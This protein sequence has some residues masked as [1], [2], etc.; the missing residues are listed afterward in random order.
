V[1]RLLLGAP[2]GTV[3]LGFESGEVIPAEVIA[4]FPDGRKKLYQLTQWL[5]VLEELGERHRVLLVTRRKSAFDELAER[6]TLQAAHAPLLRHL[7][8]LYA[9]ND[10]KVALYVNNG[11]R[12][13]QSLADQSML[14]VHV[15]HGESD[16]LCMVSNQVKA[17]DRVLVAGEA[18]LRRHRAALLAFDEEKL[19]TVGRPQLDFIPEP[20]IP[21]SERR[22]VLYAPTWEGEDE[23]N[24]YT[25]VD[26]YGPRIVQTVLTQPNVRV[27][28]KPHP[29]VAGSADEGVSAGHAR[30]VALIEA[31]SEADPTAGH[32]VQLDGDILALLPACD[33]MV[34]DVS[35]VALDFL[36]LNT[37][38]PL[39]LTDRRDDPERLAREAPVSRAS[40]VIDSSSLDGLAR[41]LSETS[42]DETL[43]AERRELRRF[44]FGDL[45][46][47]QSTE[48]FVACVEELIR[49]R[50]KLMAEQA[51][52]GLLRGLSGAE[53]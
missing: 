34:A 22:T 33:V 6:T 11:V 25:S 8:E 23:E 53:D 10:F 5:P 18:A 7:S 51:E 38:R 43:R 21:P 31:A 4:Y 27:V 42:L 44:Y 24:N 49:E 47:G 9:S 19:A 39:L 16:K 2:A 12:N 50:D 37:D 14:H 17:Y 48:R 40:H 45:G 32:T 26:V 29:R 3:P 28:Y 30:I 36:Y 15:N 52:S 1:H 20:S 13:F 35:S 46:V 41:A